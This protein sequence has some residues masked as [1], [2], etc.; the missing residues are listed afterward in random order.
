MNSLD[1]NI[2][3]YAINSGC[4]EHP[5]AK[6]VYESMLA[7]PNNWIIS[8]QVLFELYRG[9]RNGRILERP[10][11]HGQALHQI[12][13]LREDAGVLHCSYETSFWKKLTVGFI[14]TSRKSTHIF[15]RTLGITLIQHG[16]DHFYTRNTKDFTE[17]GF[18]K[19][20]NPI[21]DSV[22]K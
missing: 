19:L 12:V 17:F 6:L 8:D 15:D 9:L 4:E 7:D 20:I 22:S 5:Q 3:I 16:V 11:T 18:K 2:L 14:D 21:D 1:T 13:F 10:L